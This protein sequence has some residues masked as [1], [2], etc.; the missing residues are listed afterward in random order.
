MP[1][2]KRG[3]T[4]R[5]C[6]TRQQHHPLQAVSGDVG[7]VYELPKKRRVPNPSPYDASSPHRRER[8]E[9]DGRNT[10]GSSPSRQKVP[11]VRQPRKSRGPTLCLCSTHSPPLQRVDRILAIHAYA[12]IRRS[13]HL[14]GGCGTPLKVVETWLLLQRSLTSSLF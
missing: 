12:A 1:P 6:W 5:T 9:D 2:G 14:K 8:D 13:A 3:R 4:R 7:V 11:G 10:Y